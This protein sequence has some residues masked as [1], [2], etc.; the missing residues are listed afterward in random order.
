[1]RSTV[2]NLSIILIGSEQKDKNQKTIAC[3]KN[4]VEQI[5]GSVQLLVYGTSENLSGLDVL[6]KNLQVDVVA[7]FQ[8]S[9]DS[10][11]FADA[12]NRVTKEFTTQLYGGDTWSTGAVVEVEKQLEKNATQRIIMLS[13]MM[14]DGT[15]GAFA[16]E[17]STKKVCVQKLMEKFTCYPFYFGGT[18]IDSKLLKNYQFQQ[19]LPLD[20][21]RKFFLD[22][23]AEIKQVLFLADYSYNSIQER[24]GDT[25]FFKG[26]YLE[27][28]YNQS[29]ADFWIPYLQELKD[30]YGS[31]PVFIQYHF[32]FSVR[33]RINSNLNNKNKHVIEEGQE[34]A[35]FELVGKAFQYLD[36][37]HIF[38]CHKVSEAL[39]TDSLKWVYGI[40][41]YGDDFCFDKSYLGGLP[42]YSSKESVFNS[43]TNLK[44]NI[45]FMDYR[46][47]KMEIDGTVHPVL[48]A[49]SDEVFFTFAG[50]K[51]NLEYNERYAIT[52]AMGVSLYKSRSFHVSIPMQEFK[53]ELLFCFAK[54]GT[55]PV[56]IRFSYDS[57]F[58]RMS[59]QFPSSYW[60]FGT[61]K[62]YM[63]MKD[64]DGIRFQVTTPARRR[65]QELKL[66]KEML[67]SKDKRAWL[68][69]LV[70]NAYF[71]AKP[72]MKR[73][74]IWMYIDKIYKAGDS[75][76][77]LYRY[78]SAQGKSI[79]HYYLVDKHAADYKRLKR[80]GYK[81]LVRGSIKHRLVFL[82]ADMMVISNSTVFAFNNF[83][84]VNSSFIRDLVDFHVCCV[85]H[86]MSVQ[87]IA[88][89]Q[90]RLRDNTRLYFCA[91]PYEIKNLSHP[92]YDYEGYNALKLTGVPRYDGLV[93][94]DQKQI[95]ISPTW[96]MQVA[97]PVR[98]NEG[99][100]RDY[101]P[102]FKESEYYKVF[103][104]LINDKRL[105]SAAK[106][107]GYK[108]K[109]V[110][111]PIVSAQVD[112]FDKNE[113]VDIIPAVGDMSYEKM[114]CESS[115]MVTDFS[116]IQFDFAYMRKPLVYLHHKDIPQHYE[117][118]TFFY[119]TMAFGEICHDNDELID[120]LC[121]YMKTG[122]QMKDEY[123]A[124]ADDFFYYDDHNNCQRIYDTMI[125]YQNRYILHR[126]SQRQFVFETGKNYVMDVKKR[127]TAKK[128]LRAIVKESGAKIG[129]ATIADSFFDEAVK[130]KTVLMVG[131]GKN[132]RGSLQY[133]LNELNHNPQYEGFSVYVR[134]SEETDAV[135]QEYIRKNSWT[136]TQSVVDNK[137]Y[138]DLMESCKYLIT[139]VYFPESWIKKPEQVYI[140]I[141][142]GTPLKKL[143]LAKH[144]NVLHK[145]GVTQRNFIEADY[146]LYPNDYTKKHMLDSYK[147][148]GLM[149]GK[150]V[151]LGYP[152]T[153]GMLEA[154]E[155]D[156]T[157]LK[158]QLAPNGERI[159][160]Y[161]PTWKDY[162]AVEQVVAESKE[163]LEYL[164]NHL[165]NDQILYVN[166]HH[167]VSDSL[168]YSAFKKIK[169]FPPTTD[170]YELLAATDALIT[171]YSSVFYDYLALRKQVVL[172]CADYELYREKRG[173]YMDLMELPFDK[174]RTKEAVLDALNRGKQY[175]DQDAYDTF[176]A[177][178]SKDNAQKLCSLLIDESSGGVILEDIPR[179]QKKKLLFYSDACEASKQTTML[180]KLVASYNTSLSQIYIG[181]EMSKV[182]MNKASAYPMLAN[183]PVIGTKQDPHLSAVGKAVLKLYTDGGVD[184]DKAM[185]YLQYDY[186]LVPTRMFGRAKFDAVFIYDVLDP[187][188]IISLAMMDADKYL[189]INAGMI[190]EI[191]N[192]NE[193]LA[194]AVK[195]AADY[196]R[197]IFVEMEEQ[198]I[199]VETMLELKQAIQ[200]VDAVDVLE[201]LVNTIVNMDK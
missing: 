85:Q 32:M 195:Y 66:Q 157:E 42:Y 93:N 165:A 45:L 60:C 7:G 194:N 35:F 6:P 15:I 81:P 180:E 28:Y 148:A 166:L 154:A 43:I 78:A 143:G 107:Y 110:L 51:Y 116:G 76:E 4:E 121:E 91:S 64:E 75:S 29:I 47:G 48:Y 5:K 187:E 113:F 158:K 150:A 186:A 146:L 147:V 94:N 2:M 103:N 102:L 59:G 77:Y 9:S 34:Q 177:Y 129:K 38:N 61:D 40:L 21:E 57:H 101:N 10:V 184:F 90:N 71:V 200:V 127:K 132:V 111:H 30:K 173:T 100:Q 167:K 88:V 12:A 144:A 41:K 108:I 49:M 123:V 119:D 63:A 117:E 109:Y 153:G 115:L 176:C 56:K 87:K 46:D 198:K 183:I 24:E 137:E 8:D 120:V 3:I 97:V 114:F 168:D 55:E 196:V 136:R 131:L 189:F 73:K 124:R 19:N 86:G 125:E 17:L 164:D 172:Y 67:F 160:A 118:G 130:D 149:Q 80:D 128:E 193:F 162:L 161:M 181:C 171:D 182:D 134:T 199:V 152:R 72:F 20:S 112:D 79:K 104:A 53:N 39:V 170:N 13:K 140:N 139:E 151:M 133:I 25:T 70:R 16:N 33:S 37:K 96:R 92:I 22:I 98:T 23:C 201:D 54:F 141:W 145:D 26:V 192:G 175:D 126:D 159:Y 84:M 82:M 27:E 179:I 52:K 74:P 50:K 58:S 178:D 138:R 44:T 106:E 122:C 18:F 185:E 156:L 11:I 163:L 188:R 83:G 69:L 36:D 95:L 135:V 142:H 105:I 191:K 99:V 65:K 62:R 197:A 174:A 155:R 169:K 68:F 89:A 31:V 1:M 14:P 190:K